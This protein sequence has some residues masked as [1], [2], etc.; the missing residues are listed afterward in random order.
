MSK[1]CRDMLFSL[2]FSLL[3]LLISFPFSMIFVC[4]YPKRSV[5][6]AFCKEQCPMSST[7]STPCS[8]YVCR[9]CITRN[10]EIC[11]RDETTYP[12]KCCD[13]KLPSHDVVKLLRDP[14]LRARY[15]RKCAEYDTPIRD[16]I[17]CCKCTDF[18]GSKD[19]TGAS[20][21]SSSALVVP[22][23][24]LIRSVAHG[25][26]HCRRCFITTCT[27]CRQAAHPSRLCQDTPAD[28]AFKKLSTDKGWQKCPNCEAVVELHFGCYHIK[29]R[30][31][32][33]FCYLCAV[34]WKGC[35]CPNAE[36]GR[37]LL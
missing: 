37:L 1:P 13:R 10:V 18:L 3:L 28:V 30:C 29:C 31:S 6:C 34:K 24:T 2:L 19:T 15:E 27:A 20:S 8:H 21:S 32:T 12:P 9:S 17:Y 14:S 4:L 16:R 5:E 22:Y 7:F 25:A 36:E 23:S 26:L 11:T 33:E 35:S